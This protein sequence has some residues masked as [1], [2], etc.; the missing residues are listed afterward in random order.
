MSLDKYKDRLP[1]KLS[2]SRAKDYQQCPKLFYYKT[3]LGLPTP[4]TE[5]TARGTVAHHAFEH[6]FDH[7]K[8]ERSAEVGL[9]Y[10]LPAWNVMTNPL[11]DRSSVTV[12][13][14]EYVIREKE[15][16]FRD[17]H[18]E[19]SESELKLI[20][21]ALDYISIIPLGSDVEENF[22][23]SIENAV[24]GWFLMENPDKFNPTFREKYVN[25]SIGKAQVHGYIDR[26]DETED[27]TGKKVWISDYKTGKVPNEKYLDDAFFQLAIYALLVQAT[28]GETP[29]MLRLIYV[30]EAR[31]DAILVKKVDDKLLKSTRLKINSTWDAIQKSAKT[32]SWQPKKQVLCGWC[33]FKNICPVFNDGVEELLPEE[34][35]FRTSF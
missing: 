34:I 7:P 4:P 10:I 15:T 35:Q 21:S 23:N 12:G 13:S 24:K 9:S 32:D 3:I 26:I 29:Y 33:H 20:N 31:S 28:T 2:P 6:I 30:N 18:A 1:S 8:G 16:S 5:A 27:S 14:P 19:G 25:T 11:V 22:I 17:L